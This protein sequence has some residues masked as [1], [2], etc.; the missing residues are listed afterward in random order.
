MAADTTWHLPAAGLVLGGEA[1]GAPGGQDQ[2]DEEMDGGRDSQGLWRGV[3]LAGLQCLHATPHG[4]RSVV[5]PMPCPDVP[6]EVMN[7]TRMNTLQ[8]ELL[9]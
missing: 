8:E 6:F 3:W 7:R 4:L 1:Q 2:R 5:T 9:R